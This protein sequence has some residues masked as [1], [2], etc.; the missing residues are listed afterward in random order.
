[1][2]RASP[3]FLARVERAPQV[4]SQAVVEEL[5]P[6]VERAAAP[7]GDASRRLV[8]GNATA[9]QLRERGAGAAAGRIAPG[10]LQGA[11]KRGALVLRHRDDGDRSEEHTSE[12]QS[13]RHLVC[14]LLL[15]KKDIIRRDSDLPSTLTTLFLLLLVSALL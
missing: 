14:R 6:A 12:L 15:E 11:A 5:A 3:P 13:L 1:M 9:A 7:V 8:H 10:R 4:G 2:R